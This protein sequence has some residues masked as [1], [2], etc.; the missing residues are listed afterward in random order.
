MHSQYADDTAILVSDKNIET[1]NCKVN[2]ELKNI[3]T[4]VEANRLCL[5]IHK[6]SYMVITNQKKPIQLNIRAK[7]ISI[8]KTTSAK[9]LGVILDEKLSFKEHINSLVSKL[10]YANYAFL[11]IRNFFPKYILKNL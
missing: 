4:W 9:I 3:I 7:N 5:N 8:S 2:N 11:K 6:T 1:L 10:S